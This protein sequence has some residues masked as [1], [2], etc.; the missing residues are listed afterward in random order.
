MASTGITAY[1]IRKYSTVIMPISIK[2]FA[3]K[4]SVSKTISKL[5]KGSYKINVRA[6]I[7]KGTKTAYSSWTKAKTVKIK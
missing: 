2:T 1:V 7:K 6:Y 5:A 4:K 3:A